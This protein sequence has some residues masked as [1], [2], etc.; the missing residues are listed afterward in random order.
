MK[1]FRLIN[2]THFLGISFLFFAAT[3]YAIADTEIYISKEELHEIVNNADVKYDYLGA[4]LY[5]VIA[6]ICELEDNDNS[7]IMELRNHI[8]D[9]SC[10]GLHHAVLQALAY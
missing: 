10:I 6:R 3:T 2:Y 1:K 8:E 7:I 4:E 5:D 9:G